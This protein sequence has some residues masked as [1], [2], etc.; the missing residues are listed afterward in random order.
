MAGRVKTTLLAI[1][2]EESK[3]QQLRKLAFHVTPS[4]DNRATARYS[5]IDMIMDQ[6]GVARY[7]FVFNG[8]NI[9][10]KNTRMRHA[11]TTRRFDRHVFIVLFGCWLT[12]GVA[13]V[14]Q[15]CAGVAGFFDLY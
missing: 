9:L 4:L 14:L 11:T 8:V 7:A 6:E 5:L 15:L 10:T 1:S 13:A 2:V 12:S 3:K